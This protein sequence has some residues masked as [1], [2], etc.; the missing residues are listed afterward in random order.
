MWRPLQD[1]RD[2]EDAVRK[3]D[4]HKGWVRAIEFA[5]WQGQ[6]CPNCQDCM[7]TRRLACRGWRS[8]GPGAPA[9]APAGAAEA[10]AEYLCAL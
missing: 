9:T 5:L 2:A 10:L 7:L 1:G 8:L 4:G 6:T 3:L